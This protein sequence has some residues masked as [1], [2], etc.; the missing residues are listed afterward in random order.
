MSLHQEESPELSVVILCYKAGPLVPVIVSAMT[1]VLS[2]RDITYELVLVGNYNEHEKNADTTADEV[3]KLAQSD[4]RI[5]PVIKPKEGMFGWDVRSGLRAARGNKIAF[6]DGDS[7]NPVED[8]IR[9]YD[10]LVKEEADMAATFRVT[11]HDGMQRIF[12]SRVFNILMRILFPGVG[13][14]DV[15]SKPKIFTREA[16]GKL[17]LH[18]DDWFIDAEIAIQAMRKKFVVAQVPTLF[19]KNEHRSSFVTVTTLAEFMANLLHYR[20]FGRVR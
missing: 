16:L 20:F 8:A 7:Q 18:S 5:T 13:I 15:N 17:D 3:R 11:R 19:R 14:Y 1:G 6:I 10:A 4:T 9:V 12:I 2:E